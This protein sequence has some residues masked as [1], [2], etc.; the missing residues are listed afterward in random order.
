[1]EY[2]KQFNY[3]GITILFDKIERNKQYPSFYVATRKGIVV[4]YIPIRKI[5]CNGMVRV[6]EKYSVVSFTF[7]E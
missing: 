1:M 3:H 7:N 4:G 2:S 6:D 5:I